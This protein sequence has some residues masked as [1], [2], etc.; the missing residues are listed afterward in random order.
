MHLSKIYTICKLHTL[1]I[2]ESST[3]QQ[4]RYSLA[5]VLAKHSEAAVAWN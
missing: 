4:R 5:V 1:L 3:D 2:Y